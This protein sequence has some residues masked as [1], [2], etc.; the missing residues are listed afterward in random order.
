MVVLES[1]GEG[2]HGI[3]PLCAS[4]HE[5]GGGGRAVKNILHHQGVG[6]SKFFF[7]KIKIPNSP[8]SPKTIN[9]E[10]S[11]TLLTLVTAQK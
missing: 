8:P 10:R 5:G 9:Y 6:G 7:L 11:I 4:S 1:K 2:G 3:L